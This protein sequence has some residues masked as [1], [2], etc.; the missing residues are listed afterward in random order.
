MAAYV[1]T[2]LQVAGTLFSGAGQLSQGRAEQRAANLRARQLDREAIAAE[3]ASQREAIEERRQARLLQSRARAV[4][5]AGGG[6]T[7][8]VGVTEILSRIE[9]EGEFNALSALFEGSEKAAGFR[10]GAASERYQGKLARQQ[11]RIQALN[12]FISGGSK[13]LGFG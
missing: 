9:R 4:A 10:A 7:T 12:T 13:I 1:G 5:A 3:A 6:T 2:G 11:S 8:D